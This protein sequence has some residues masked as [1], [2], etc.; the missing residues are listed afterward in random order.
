MWLV[1]YVK[2]LC[3][4]STKTYNA[5]GHTI[6]LATSCK[7]QIGRSKLLVQVFEAKG[8]TFD[9][10]LQKHGLKTSLCHG[11]GDLLLHGSSCPK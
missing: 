8:Q 1:S 11:T 2:A 10:C 6:D 3:H 4:T 9:L 7:G 5:F